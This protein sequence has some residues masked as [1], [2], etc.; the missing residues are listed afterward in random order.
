MT[1]LIVTFRD[2]V[3]APKNSERYDVLSFVPEEYVKEGRMPMHDFILECYNKYLLSF[4]G[5]VFSPRGIVLDILTF[6]LF[7]V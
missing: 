3:K 5:P 6:H 4:P 1:M 2:F 7:V